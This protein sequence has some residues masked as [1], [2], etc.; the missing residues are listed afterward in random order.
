MASPIS[1]VP[2]LLDAVGL[3]ADQQVA[4][5]VARRKHVLDRLLDNVGILAEIEG[6]AKHHGVGERLGDGIGQALARDVGRAAMDGL[7]ERLAPAG[8]VGRT[9]RGRGQEAQRSGQHRR[10]IRQD[11]AEQVV[12]DD[13]VEIARRAQ[14]LHGERVGVHVLELH[15]GILLLVK[16]GRLLAPQH[17]GVHDVGLLGRQHLVAALARQ[18]EGDG[19]DAADLAYRVALGVECLDL[20]LGVGL[21]AAR[22]AEIDAAGQLADDHDV[23][24]F[25]DLGL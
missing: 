25:D 13:D 14:Q 23:E 24:T 9:E 17:A 18:L 15:V 5:A 10:F 21:A 2:T 7:I 16:L 8:R 20:A 12:G 1:W 4:G 19:A 22:L 6:V 3:A 11:V